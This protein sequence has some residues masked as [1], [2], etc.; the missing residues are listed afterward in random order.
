MNAIEHLIHTAENEGDEKLGGVAWGRLA[1][2]ARA[3]LAALRAATRWV[4]VTERLPEQGNYVLV[5]DKWE[6]QWVAF[7]TGPENDWVWLAGR[8]H[9]PLVGITHWQPLPPAP[10]K[11]HGPL[12]PPKETT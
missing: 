10:G 8:G 5:H 12:T 3:E 6:I 2:A 9:E 1:K 11:D 7:R 4:P